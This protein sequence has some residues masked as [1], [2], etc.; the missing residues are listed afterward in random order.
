MYND[1]Y[2]IERI[3]NEREN[4]YFNQLFEEDSENYFDG[5]I[6]ED[7]N[8]EFSENEIKELKLENLRN[9]LFNKFVDLLDIL[10]TTGNLSK[11]EWNKYFKFSEYFDKFEFNKKND[12]IEFPIR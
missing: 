6:E 9:K 5:F 12:W 1:S 3:L 10:H 8:F 7:I 11:K 4:E 2:V